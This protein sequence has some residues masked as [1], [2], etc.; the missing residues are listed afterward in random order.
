MGHLGSWRGT[1]AGIAL[2]LHAPA[3]FSAAAFWIPIFDGLTWTFLES[4]QYQNSS[5]FLRQLGARQS[6]CSLQRRGRADH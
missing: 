5:L 2:A 4:G 6:Y 3:A 1:A